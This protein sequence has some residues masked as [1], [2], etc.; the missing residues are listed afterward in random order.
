MD[1]QVRNY[2]RKNTM[3]GRDSAALVSCFPFKFNE[4]NELPQSHMSNDAY[5]MRP[6]HI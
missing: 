6:M 5:R 3:A 1:G 4:W 2:F